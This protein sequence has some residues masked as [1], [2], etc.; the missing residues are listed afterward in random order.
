MGDVDSVGTSRLSSF[1][2][3]NGLDPPT[4]AVETS[5][6]G[7]LNLLA[8]GN[9]LGLMPTRSQLRRICWR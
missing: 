6:I 7:M 3:A 5:A 1:F 8:E 4:I 9:F 2:V